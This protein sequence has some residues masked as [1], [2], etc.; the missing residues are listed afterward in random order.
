M[1]A[2]AS[3]SS[4]HLSSVF[5]SLLSSATFLPSAEVRMIMPKFLGL[6]AS[7]MRR[8]RS[9]SSVVF[10]FWDIEIL[11][12]NGMRTIYRPV[13]VISVVRRGPFDEMGSLTI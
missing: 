3:V 2:L 4:Q 8:R 9:F 11:S 1:R 13:K 5:S 12:P 6:I 10:I 7:S